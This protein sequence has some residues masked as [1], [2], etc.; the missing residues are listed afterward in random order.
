M[1][2]YDAAVDRHTFLGGA[3]PVAPRLARPSPSLPRSRRRELFAESPTQ[4][5]L[6]IRPWT[7]TFVREG[8]RVVRVD[9]LD[10]GEIASGPK[11][12]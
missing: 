3:N 6:E 1:A 10:S 5:F 4:F 9:L 12:E 2:K 11:I 8:E 7:L